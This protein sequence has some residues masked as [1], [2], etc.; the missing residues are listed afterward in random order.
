MKIYTKIVWDIATGA[1]DSEEHFEYTGKVDLLCGASSAQNQVQAAQASAYTQMTQQAQ[2]IF[3]AD[4][5][6]FQQLQA[7]FAPTIAAGPN[8]QGFSAQENANLNSQA[9]TQNGIAARNAKQ[10]AGEAIASQGGG[11][12][13]ALQSGVDT[14]IENQINI[15]SANNTANEEGQITEQ[16][17][18][19]GRQ[20]YD[21]AVT[22]LENAT[23][24]F[25]S[26]STA[27]NAATN[28]GEA[29]A[30]TANNIASQNNSWVQAVTGALGGV[31]G[32]FVGGGIGKMITGGGGSGT[33]PT[34]S[35]ANGPY[36][37]NSD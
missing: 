36:G 7:S 18:A 9:I 25:N 16:N 29:D 10:A 20:N 4:S 30:T 17:Y 13:A 26:A 15:S 27:G 14:G 31:A 6:V 37:P 21:T 24:G 23:N 28:S 2:Q 8:Q 34:G 35:S 19:T 22:G 5:S 3:G 1:I 33:T 11:N 12:N 32:S